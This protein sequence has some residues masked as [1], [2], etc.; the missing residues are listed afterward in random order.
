MKILFGLLITVSFVVVVTSCQKEVDWSLPN[1]TTT[2]ST[3]LWK[4]V[5]IDTTLSAGLDTLEVHYFEYDNQKRLTRLIDSLREDTSSSPAYTSSSGTDLFYNGNETLPFKSIQIDKDGADRRWD[6]AYFSYQGQL[7]SMDSSRVQISNF[8]GNTWGIV[9][10][11]F[12]KSGNSVT[13]IERFP[14][15]PGPPTC[16]TTS[17]IA[18]TYSSG[19]IASEM[20][21]STGCVTGSWDDQMTYDNK[22]NPFYKAIPVHYPVTDYSFMGNDQNNNMTEESSLSMGIHTQR[23]YT[24]RSN[25]L[26]SVVRVNDLNFPGYSYKGIYYYKN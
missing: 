16:E 24:Y 25:G 14:N 17:I 20:A 26:P 6:T 15:P 18:Q 11:Y 10:L 8:S 19:N 5:V 13:M 7:V 1:T 3:V 9:A 23:T 22:M 4:Y 12:T 2:D 21:T